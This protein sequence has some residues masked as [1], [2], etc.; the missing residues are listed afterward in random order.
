MCEVVD[1]SKVTVA[2]SSHAYRD[3][4]Q[5]NARY[6]TVSDLYKKNH[7]NQTY[8]YVIKQKE[9][10][11]RLNHTQLTMWQAFDLLESVVDDSDPDIEKGQLVHAIQTAESLRTKYP[12]PSYDWIH[13]V[14]LIHDLGKILVNFGEPQWA[15]VGDT[16]P[17]G[18]AYDPRIVYNQFFESNTDSKK[19]ELQTE[20]GIYNPNCGLS[21]IHLSWGH[22]EYMYIV[23]KGNNSTLPE[24]ALNIIR[25]HSF[26]P[27]HQGGAYRNLMT[28]EDHKLLKIVKD[29]QVHDLYSKTDNTE[30]LPD[31]AA[32]KTYYS[33]LMKKYFPAETLRW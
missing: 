32:L 10:W 29:F 21:N 5:N 24:Q 18:C 2:D 23:C 33:G 12:D 28:E 17:V 1:P 26:Y 16:F 7:I 20:Y 14:G 27:W 4:T 31:I 3:Y 9:K 30:A 13:L 15:V 8:D 11:S 25:F 22:D 6:A 19:P